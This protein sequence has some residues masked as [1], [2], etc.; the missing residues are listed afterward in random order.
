MKSGSGSG[1][2][3]P[4]S[5]EQDDKHGGDKEGVDVNDDDDDVGVD[6]QHEHNR[7]LSL[8]RRRDQKRSTNVYFCHNYFGYFYTPVGPNDPA[9]L[10]NNTSNSNV[11]RTV[12]NF[13]LMSILFGA[14]HG[15]VVGT[16]S[17]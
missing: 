15:C 10:H 7:G 1:R 2:Y 3:E 6:G 4:L 14:S 17:H 16:Y 8:R 5:I 13:I 12:R 9:T 11:R